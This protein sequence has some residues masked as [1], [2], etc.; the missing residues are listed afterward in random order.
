MRE[1]PGGR[2]HILSDIETPELPTTTE[3]AHRMLLEAARLRSTDGDD[4]EPSPWSLFRANELETRARRFL[5]LTPRL[6]DDTNL[7]PGTGGELEPI[8]QDAYNLPGIVDTVR[9]P[10]H[11][12]LE[13]SNERLN[14]ADGADAFHLAADAAETIGARNSLEKM[15]AHQMAAAHVAAMRSLERAAEEERQADLFAPASESRRACNIEAV[16]QRNSAARIMRAYQGGMLTLA[17]LRR[18]NSQTVNVVHQHVSAPGGQVAVAGMVSNPGGA[19]G[20]SH[21]E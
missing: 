17:K 7:T 13:A 16:R 9:R 3:E 18:G 15:Q 11:V 1:A 20:G 19:G 21:G 8:G 5:D 4:P 6:N 12:A 14:L 2:S 10:H